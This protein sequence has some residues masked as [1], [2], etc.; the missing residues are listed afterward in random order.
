M[1]PTPTLA[2]YLAG[3]ALA[4]LIVLLLLIGAMGP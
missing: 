4:V 1:R 2:D 3:A